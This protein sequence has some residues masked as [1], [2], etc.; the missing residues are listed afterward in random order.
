MKN[1][2]IWFGQCRLFDVIDVVFSRFST[3]RTRDGRVTAM[4]AMRDRSARAHH[5][6]HYNTPVK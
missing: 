4:R 3:S 1:L 6:R 5:M 2:E